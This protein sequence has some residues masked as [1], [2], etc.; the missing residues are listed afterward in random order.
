MVEDLNLRNIVFQLNRESCHQL[1]VCLTLYILVTTK[2]VIWQTVKAVFHQN[3]HC[4][5]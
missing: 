2:G 1:S 3:L 5:L 4:L